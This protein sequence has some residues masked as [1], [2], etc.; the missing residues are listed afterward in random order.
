MFCSDGYSVDFILEKYAIRRKTKEELQEEEK[1]TRSGK[2]VVNKKTRKRNR[3]KL[4]EENKEEEKG[5]TEQE[6]PKKRKKEENREKEV[7]KMEEEI[8]EKEMD[9][10]EMEKKEVGNLQN[11]GIID[12]NNI[13]DLSKY[14][15]V[16]FDPGATQAF[17]T[18]DG[19]K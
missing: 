5:E 13:E 3:K 16:P 7:D 10:M 18:P 15:I 2:R 8:C 11:S 14:R 1:K 17:F 12:L 9:E 19:L 4:N 6:N